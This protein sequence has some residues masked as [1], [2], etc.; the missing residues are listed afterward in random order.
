MQKKRVDLD[1]LQSK[2]TL[3]IELSEFLNLQKFFFHKFKLFF[4]L[5]FRAKL[6]SNAKKGKKKGKIFSLEIL[7]FQKAD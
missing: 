3:L 2:T 6:K 1:D 4:L 5:F 7:E